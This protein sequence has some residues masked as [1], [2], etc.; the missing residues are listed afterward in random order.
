[1]LKSTLFICKS[2]TWDKKQE[3]QVF[4]QKAAG[5]C[6]R[7][8]VGLRPSPGYV[9]FLTLSEVSKETSVVPS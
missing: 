6:G 7:E 1:M 3:R 5:S 2:F 8:G 4:Q 9:P